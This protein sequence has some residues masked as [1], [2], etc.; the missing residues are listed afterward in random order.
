MHETR[1][2]QGLIGIV[3]LL[4]WAGAA[5]AAPRVVASIAPIQSLVAGVMQGV[6]S[7]DLLIRGAGSPH[8]FSLK[9]S[10][11]RAMSEAD[12]V[13]WVGP[14]MESFLE[15]PIATLPGSTRIVTLSQVPG[16]RLLEGRRGGAWEADEHD[17]H[18]GH[19]RHDHGDH[20]HDLHLWL[21]PANA[22][23]ILAAVAQA[24]SAADPANAARY[25]SNAEAAQTRI[26]GL[27]SE[28]ETMVAPVRRRP[29][30]VFHDA[31]QY[32]EARFGL[33]P[34]GSIAVNPERKAGARRLYEI[35]KK[36]VESG[37]R[38]V[39]REPQFEPKLVHTIV[40][41]TEARIAVLDPLGAGVQP[42]PEAYFAILRNLAG[43]LRDCLATAS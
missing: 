32:F 12:L 42:G 33:H 2:K 19:G 10:D 31:Y 34:A 1:W 16:I 13:V 4:G 39:F 5:S 7:P 21:D 3:L 17:D 15:R 40:E 43:A 20:H 6:G 27:V 29:Y 30:V 41:G 9:P 38:C 22:G 36:I 14:G 8:S 25:T 37:A 28:I 26:D 23:A 18:S 35:R 24:L 11:A